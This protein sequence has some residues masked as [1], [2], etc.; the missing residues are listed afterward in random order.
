MGI[1][2]YSDDMSDYDGYEDRWYEKNVSRYRDDVAYEREH[3][4]DYIYE[5]EAPPKTP[6][7]GAPKPEPP[8]EPHKTRN[9]ILELLFIILSVGSVIYLAFYL[10]SED[11]DASFLPF[12]NRNASIA[13]NVSKPH[14]AVN[15]AVSLLKH[16][17][18][19]Q[20]QKEYL[21]ENYRDLLTHDADEFQKLF[22]DAM[23]GHDVMYETY[24]K[25]N[26]KAEH[27]QEKA[28]ME[29]RKKLIDN[30]SKD[31]EVFLA[32]RERLR[33]D[34]IVSG[35]LWRVYDKRGKLVERG[36]HGP[37][38]TKDYLAWQFG[39]PI[40]GANVTRQEIVASKLNLQRK[41][42]GNGNE[43]EVDEKRSKALDNVHF[44]ILTASARRIIDEMIKGHAELLY[45]LN[46]TGFDIQS[47][48]EDKAWD[49]EERKVLHSTR[50]EALKRSESINGH[51][52][53]LPSLLKGVVSFKSQ[54]QNTKQALL[55]LKERFSKEREALINSDQEKEDWLNDASAVLEAWTGV[56]FDMQEMVLF[57]LR[58]R[59]VAHHVT[60]QKGNI[61]EM[62]DFDKCWEIWKSQNCGQT[63]C[64]RRET[65]ENYF[66]WWW[67][68]YTGKP[69]AWI[70]YMEKHWSF[71]VGG[72]KKT[73]IWTGIYENACCNDSK[74]AELLKYGSKEPP[75][76]KWKEVKEEVKKE[77]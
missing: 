27:L 19:Y 14:I 16:K 76:E 23:L 31:Y 9:S 40:T 49:A 57:D 35:G 29:E 17:D 44:T 64:Y 68:G 51:E 10:F 11:P 26:D 56:V 67:S 47:S 5:D 39:T 24:F 6:G 66:K 42:Y 58:R 70:A 13:H 1:S 54:I 59:E 53:G 4:Q 69:V 33:R 43:S 65:P 22:D 60:L 32:R 30:L 15:K 71:E 20:A 74:L 37:R 61:R 8:A 21:F 25:K 18:P 72:T 28:H 73:G 46:G 45:G 34:L 12:L 2:E 36:E 75:K 55:L 48:L 7:F 3:I 38:N 50:K 63:T 41:V 62:F 77:L 52:Y